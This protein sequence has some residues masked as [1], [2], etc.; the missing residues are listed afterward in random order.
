MFE[1]IVAM[2]LARLSLLFLPLAGGV[3]IQVIAMDGAGKLAESMEGRPEPAGEC[4][5]S[6]SP[7]PE[8]W[9]QLLE[10]VNTLDQERPAGELCP[11]LPLVD[12]CMAV[13]QCQD[14]R[15]Q[16]FKSLQTLLWQ[17]TFNA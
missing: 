13:H 3:T 9:P 6:S 11:Q 5:N 14:V 15:S 12:H 8:S 1:S 7:R 17:D 4:P 10:D 2:S 16:P